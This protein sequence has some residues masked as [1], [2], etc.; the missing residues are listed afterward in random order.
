MWFS[1]HRAVI[2]NT[3]HKEKDMSIETS[4]AR[5]AIHDKLEA[6]IKT[7]E[8]KLDTLK[9]RAEAGKA[10]AEIKALADL[11]VQRM[12]IHQ[13]L[14]ELKRAAEDLW[15]HAETDLVLRIAAFEKAVKAIEA[16]SKAH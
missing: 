6:E 10:N 3:T 12:E 7:I 2:P 16:K 15:E 11:A 5:R 1:K 4:T 14:Q 9:A 8:A 13:K